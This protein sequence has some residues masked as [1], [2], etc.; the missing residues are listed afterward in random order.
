MHRARSQAFDKEGLRCGA[1]LRVVECRAL[2]EHELEP[3]SSGARG[4]YL[5]EVEAEE[6]ELDELEIL[7]GPEL[8]SEVS[9]VEEQVGEGPSLFLFSS[10]TMAVA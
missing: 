6:L 8:A 1:L 7:T 9:T 2:A 3:L 5:E 10:T 4:D